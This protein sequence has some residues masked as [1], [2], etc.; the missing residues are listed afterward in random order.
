[1]L[2]FISLFTLEQKYFQNIIITDGLVSGGV[3]IDFG[4]NIDKENKKVNKSPFLF[5]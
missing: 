3:D 2:R 4:V 1:M 5:T